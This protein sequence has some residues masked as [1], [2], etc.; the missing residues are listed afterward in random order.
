MAD[1]KWP[2]L[3]ENLMVLV[4][5]RSIF[6]HMRVARMVNYKKV[7]PKGNYKEKCLGWHKMTTFSEN[8]MLFSHSEVHFWSYEGSGNGKLQKLSPT[9]KSTNNPQRQS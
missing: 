9:G 2:L 4:I 3:V 5:L 7:S 8:L 6:G 1:T